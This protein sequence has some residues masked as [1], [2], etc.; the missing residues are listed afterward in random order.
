M[1]TMKEVQYHFFYLSSWLVGFFFGYLI[2][3]LIITNY[4]KN[5][6]TINFLCSLQQREMQGLDVEK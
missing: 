3:E 1:E 4:K 2:L 6:P 5:V